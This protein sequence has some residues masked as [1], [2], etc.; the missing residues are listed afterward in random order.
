MGG[1]SMNIEPRPIEVK[2]L[3]DYKLYLKFETGEEK[4]YDMKTWIE[5]YATYRRL[6]DETYFRKVRTR[7]CT[8][9]WENGEDVAPE[10]LYQDSI[11]IDN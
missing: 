9:E 2:A 10:Y 1:S 5:N 7:G 4:I 6:K 11:P 8:V 3:D